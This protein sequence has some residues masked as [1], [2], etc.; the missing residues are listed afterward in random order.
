MTLFKYHLLSFIQ[1]HFTQAPNKKKYLW[2]TFIMLTQALSYGFVFY[3]IGVFF[4]ISSFINLAITNRL[5]HIL[6]LAPVFCFHGWFWG[7]K[8][9]SLSQQYNLNTFYMLFLFIF[10]TF[11]AVFFF[12]VRI[13]TF[14]HVFVLT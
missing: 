5:C 1:Q 13:L 3:W 10:S 11:M 7:K 6:T 2:L 4:N 12:D 14:L 8:T 9:I